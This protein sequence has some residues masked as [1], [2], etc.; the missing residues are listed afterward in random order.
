MVD[1][2]DWTQFKTK[3]Q[4]ERMTVITATTDGCNVLFELGPVLV[5]VAF[6]R[7]FCQKHC[8]HKHTQK[9]SY[10]VLTVMIAL[11]S[12]A[13]MTRAFPNESSK[14]KDLVLLQNIASYMLLACGLIYV[15]SVS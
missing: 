12:V 14:Q 5:L 7:S 11:F 9:Y 10:L 4:I 15:I 8:M 3:L 6:Y 2:S 1:S 13:V